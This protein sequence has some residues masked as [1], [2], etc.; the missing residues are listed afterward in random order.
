MRFPWQKKKTDARPKVESVDSLPPTIAGSQ[1]SVETEQV[2]P[3]FLRPQF[4]IQ[5]PFRLNDYA[6]L[7]IEDSLSKA[8][9][10]ADVNL[11]V[12]EFEFLSEDDATNE[13]LKDFAHRID[14]ERVAWEAYRDQSLYGFACGEIIGDGA[15]LQTS[16][17][18]L[19][20][21]RL[22]PRYIFIQKDKKGRIDHF[23]QRWN[24]ITPSV[25][26]LDNRF[27]PQTIFYN[28]SLSPITS[29]GQS[30]LQSIKGRLQQR[31]DL[32]AAL[33]KANIDH[34]NVIHWL[35]YLGDKEREEVQ[36]END[37]Q[38]AAMGKATKDIDENLTK[39]LLSAGIGGYHHEVIGGN[40]ELPDSSNLLRELT[41]DI[42]SSAGFGPSIF[43][44]TEG[45]SSDQE[46]SRYT[47]NSILTKQKLFMSQLHAKLFSILPFVESECPAQ[48][49]DDIKV[50]MKPPTQQSIKEM[51][52]SEA[53]KINNIGLKLRMGAIGAD[54]A[55]RELNYFS[56]ENEGMLEKFL[57]GNT[58]KGVNP[59]DPN[60]TQQVK[61]SLNSLNSGKSPSNNPSGKKGDS[62]N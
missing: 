35:Q 49:A 41:R 44:V 46:Q 59:N 9:V 28:H 51:L 54:Q 53:I 30:L 56:W 21:K 6:R 26:L 22:D 33:V 50:T 5:H 48:R 17:K 24:L 40:N 19:A 31:N 55:A 43:G 37:R 45:K 23:I 18:I 52:E 14:L 27:D 12:S 61:A 42:I 25:G 3:M 36:A 39:W 15:T 7:Y 2:L 58:D 8:I 16:T 13:Y 47:T 4:G 11:T 10:D 60:Q 29:Y 1:K 34:A 38:I 62:N 32:I 57:Q 20:V